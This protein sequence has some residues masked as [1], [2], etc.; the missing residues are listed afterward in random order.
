MV[1]VNGEE[2]DALLALARGRR[3]RAGGGGVVPGAPAPAPAPERNAALIRAILDGADAP[4]LAVDL[5]LIN[6][7]AAIYA[8]GAADSLKEGVEAAREALA[9]GRA[10]AALERFVEASREHAPAQATP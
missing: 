8:G 3:H 2:L 7:G 6:S 9:D 1:E 10:A 4:G 5:A